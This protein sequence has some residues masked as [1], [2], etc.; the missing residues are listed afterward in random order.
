MIVNTQNARL[1]ILLAI[2]TSDAAEA[3]PQQSSA[4]PSK[5]NII[6]MM[7]K[8]NYALFIYFVSRCNHDTA[9]TCVNK[10]VFVLLALLLPPLSIPCSTAN[11]RIFM[12]VGGVVCNMTEWY[13]W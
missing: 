12:V 1:L 7:A 4:R 3:R 13:P 10:D 5:P 11:F 8:E 9:V 6:I 2:F